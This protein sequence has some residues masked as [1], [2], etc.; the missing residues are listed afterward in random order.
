MSRLLPTVALPWSA[1]TSSAL[2]ELLSLNRTCNGRNRKVAFAA[3]VRG[4]EYCSRSLRHWGRQELA[5]ETTR[6]CCAGPRT[7]TFFP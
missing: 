7:R 4:T 1:C 2:A 5:A 6:V 3:R